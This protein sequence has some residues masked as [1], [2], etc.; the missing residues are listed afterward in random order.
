MG[1]KKRQLWVLLENAKGTF[2]KCNT[3]FRGKKKPTPELFEQFNLIPH[4]H[5]D[6][7]KFSDVRENPHPS[8]VT[9]LLPKG[10][11]CILNAKLFASIY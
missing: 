8:M 3:L 4:L 10:R 2:L 9:K 7:S 1:E 6:L 11:Y 5:S